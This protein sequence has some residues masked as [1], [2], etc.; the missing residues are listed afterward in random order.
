MVSM[1]KAMI[2]VGLMIARVSSYAGRNLSDVLR[3]L[4]RRGLNVVFSSELVKPEMKV[5]EE[6]RATTPRKILD[7][8]LAPHGLAVRSGPR[9]SLIVIKAKSPP[10]ATASG[11][12]G[13]I[14]GRVVDARTGEPLPV[15][16]CRWSAHRASRSPMRT[17]RLR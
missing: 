1:T 14:T 17:E 8:V 11:P 2:V 4:Q 6:P 16:W 12:S 5:T 9:R 7:E 10:A 13:S 3:E 15:F